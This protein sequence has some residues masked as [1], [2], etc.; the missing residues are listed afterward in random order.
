MKTSSAILSA[1][2]HSSLM[3]ASAS[4]ADSTAPVCQPTLQTHTDRHSCLNCFW[5]SLILCYTKYTYWPHRREIISLIAFVCPS[6]FPMLC[7]TLT[8]A[9][10]VGHHWPALCH[11]PTMGGLLFWEVRIT[12][13]FFIFW[14]FI[15]NMQK[16]DTFW[17][18]ITANF[19][20]GSQRTYT[21]GAQGHRCIVIS[22]ADENIHT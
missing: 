14:W 8:V 11:Q 20:M 22:H 19:Q 3:R 7:T 10:Y 21:G 13:T 15:W 17:P 6:V 4:K 9:S 18:W 12:P 16:T 5:T 1:S 2:P